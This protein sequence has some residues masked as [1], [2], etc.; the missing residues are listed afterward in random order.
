MAVIVFVLESLKGKEA[1]VQGQKES[2][3][4][5]EDEDHL[6]RSTF[7]STERERFVG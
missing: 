7:S 3:E 4:Y 5:N 6:C 2:K 1:K